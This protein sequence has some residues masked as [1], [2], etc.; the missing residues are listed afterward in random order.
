MLAHLHP[1]PVLELTEAL[2][3]HHAAKVALL[4]I[5]DRLLER[6]VRVVAV[7]VIVHLFGGDGGH[8]ED[9]HFGH[10]EG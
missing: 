8:L 5:V 2:L 7:H 9:E 4:L 1:D 3:G 10:V 6:D